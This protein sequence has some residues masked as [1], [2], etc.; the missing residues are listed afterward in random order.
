MSSGFRALHPFVIFIYYSGA[1]LLLLFMFHP[2]FIVVAMIVMCAVNVLYDGGRQLWRWKKMILITSLLFV[3]INIFTSQRGSHLLWQV[4][5]HRITLEATLYGMMM[6]G[7]IFLVLALFVSYQQVLTMDQFFY[8]FARITPQWALLSALAI[9]FVPLMKL[10]LEEIQKVQH[11]QHRGSLKSWKLKIKEKMKRLEVL[12]TW[13]LEGG[14]QTAESMK[15]RGYG[16]VKR[17]TAYTL[18]RWRISD[19]LY[20]VFLSVLFTLCIWGWIHGLGRLEIYPVMENGALSMYEWIILGGYLTY[21]S[22]PIYV[23]IGADA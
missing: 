18:Y 12:M 3:G 4:G 7:T 6:A 22:F 13:S 20:F 21:L 8:L 9:R 15:A 5:D 16:T 23:E 2:A 11:L 1:I 17:R 19:F 14:L 10:R